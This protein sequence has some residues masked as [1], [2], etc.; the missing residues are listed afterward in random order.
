MLNQ[1]NREAFATEQAQVT[2]Q[3]ADLAASRQHTAV[4]ADVQQLVHEL[5][6][7][8]VPVAAAHILVRRTTGVPH[9]LWLLVQRLE[10]RIIELEREVKAL[11]QPAHMTTVERR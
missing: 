7:A 8:G 3:I 4:P 2:K 9:E 10:G 11:R 1:I 5:G 6:Q